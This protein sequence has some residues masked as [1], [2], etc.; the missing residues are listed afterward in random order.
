MQPELFYFLSL[1]ALH[2]PRRRHCNGI[3]DRES[4][5]KRLLF[6]LGFIRN[7]RDAV[8]HQ[9]HSDAAFLRLQVSS[10]IAILIICY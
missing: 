4:L 10:T 9:T 5:W 2:V 8:K 3:L 7:I 6:I 1:W